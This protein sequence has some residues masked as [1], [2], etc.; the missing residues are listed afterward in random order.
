MDNLKTMSRAELFQCTV[1]AIKRSQEADTADQGK[2]ECNECRYEWIARD[3]H[4]KG[5]YDAM[6]EARRDKE[7]KS[8]NLRRL[9]NSRH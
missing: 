1:N 7:W 8:I 6:M 3:G 2:R 4:L 9:N 5:Y